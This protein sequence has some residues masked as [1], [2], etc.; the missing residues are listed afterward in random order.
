MTKNISE[1]VALGALKAYQRIYEGAKTMSKLD[2]AAEMFGSH[3]L[4]GERLAN[5]DNDSRT[6]EALADGYREGFLKAI[7]VLGMLCSCACAKRLEA[8]AGMTT[9]ELH[10]YKS[11]CCL[12][13]L[14]DLPAQI[15]KKTSPGC[16]SYYS[17]KCSKCG[18]P[19]HSACVQIFDSDG[20]EITPVDIVES[21]DGMPRWHAAHISRYNGPLCIRDLNH[22]NVYM[23]NI[24]SKYYNRGPYWKHL[25][26]LTDEDL[27]HY[28]N[29][30]REEAL[31]K[32]HH[33][34]P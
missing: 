6:R 15:I 8:F 14:Q 9:P 13:D 33:L 29:T 18:K 1:M 4:I 23:Y 30:T 24:D 28:W 2:E 26:K 21:P 12:A 10:I 22:N 34:K 5:V 16:T 25:D 32:C 20:V 17:Q 3:S 27:E 7:E 19:S 11:E 31:K